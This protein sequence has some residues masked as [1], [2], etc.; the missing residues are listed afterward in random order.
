MKIDA[1][2]VP[3][4]TA[5]FTG[6][7]DGEIKQQHD[8][9][10]LLAEANVNNREGHACKA[11]DGIDYP[12]IH[13]SGLNI[14]DGCDGTAT[15]QNAAGNDIIMDCSKNTRSTESGCE[16]TA[17]EMFLV[18]RSVDASGNNK[19]NKIASHSF[20]NIRAAN[21]AGMDMRVKAHFRDVRYKVIDQTGVEALADNIGDFTIKT[22]GLN[23]D[24]KY[25]RF[26]G[27]RA[28]LETSASLQ[29]LNFDDYPSE[30]ACV[31]RGSALS[32]NELI[33]TDNNGN[34]YMNDDA[35]VVGCSNIELNDKDEGMDAMYY[36]DVDH[37]IV[38]NDIKHVQPSYL[39]SVGNCDTCM[40]ALVIS[41]FDTQ[42]SVKIPVD[43]GDD[44]EAVS[45]AKTEYLGHIPKP[46]GTS[47]FLNWR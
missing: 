30:I 10:M 24:A 42:V 36:M 32:T 38:Y 29:K 9:F 18:S 35:E 39:E 23:I 41:G 19:Y 3:A 20:E 15:I 37:R 12:K 7:D 22:Q 6:D 44:N 27:T 26:G 43:T 47:T 34:T 14:V 2:F 31:K 21:G 13:K 8:Q 46:S 4:T 5:L 17:N 25:N 28:Q 1:A 40:N 11:T 16:K 33:S 45:P